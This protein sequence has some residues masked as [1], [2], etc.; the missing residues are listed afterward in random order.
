MKTFQ[1]GTIFNFLIAFTLFQ[2]TGN[3]LIGLPNAVIG[4]IFAT[5]SFIKGE[6]YK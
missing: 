1:F 3:P 4:A 5:I 2:A 6:G